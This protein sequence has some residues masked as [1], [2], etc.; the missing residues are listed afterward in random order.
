MGAGLA[1][2]IQPGRVFSTSDRRVYKLPPSPDPVAGVWG[3]GHFCR[4]H[5]QSGFSIG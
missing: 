5:R 4:G 3:G 2:S 1:E